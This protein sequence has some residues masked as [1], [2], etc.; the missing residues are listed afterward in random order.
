MAPRL[1]RYS[2][3]KAQQSNTMQRSSLQGYCVADSGAARTCFC[4][5]HAV[6]C[7]QVTVGHLASTGL[8]MRRLGGQQGCR[9]RLFYRP[10]WEGGELRRSRGD[11]QRLQH[12]RN[13]HE[14]ILHMLM[15]GAP[16]ISKCVL[17]SQACLR[18]HSSFDTSV[19]I[20][21]PKYANSIPFARQGVDTLVDGR[22]DE[23]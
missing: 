11:S 2:V 8:L 12:S 22:S 23:Q 5:P 17:H 9:T 6:S 10:V 19:D 4:V 7:Q 14:P 21:C 18:V 1:T 16:L 13:D 3:C 15:V 20:W